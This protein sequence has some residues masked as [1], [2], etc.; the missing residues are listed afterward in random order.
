MSMQ[1]IAPDLQQELR[2]DD[3]GKF[4][5]RHLGAVAK[6]PQD[7]QRAFV[8]QIKAENLTAAEAEREASRLLERSWRK[9]PQAR[10]GT[11]R[12]FA[13][14]SATV[15]VKFRRS[16]VTDA[17]VVDVLQ[18]ACKLLEQQTQDGSMR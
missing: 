17:E 13:I 8:E 18:R 12:R 5:R 2:V 11:T 4:S 16:G 3:S 9:Q 6:M 15:E 14:G 1:R 7:Q 10:T